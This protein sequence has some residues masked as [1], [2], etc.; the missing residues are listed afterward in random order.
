MLFE[1]APSA[2]RRAGA[3]KWQFWKSRH[4]FHFGV[5]GL[6]S[7]RATTA[8]GMEDGHDGTQTIT[9]EVDEETAEELDGLACRYG[10]DKQTLVE[11]CCEQL[12]E[13][14]R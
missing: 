14:A 10:M 2:F 3:W 1:V 5:T 7:R 9:V 11:G 12:A 6:L 4:H 13:R 8:I